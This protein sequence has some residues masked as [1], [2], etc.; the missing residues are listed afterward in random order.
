MCSHIFTD[1]HVYAGFMS[2]C[3]N[4]AQQS[5]EKVYVNGKEAPLRFAPREPGHED[6]LKKIVGEQQVC[7]Y[8][9]CMSSEVLFM[10]IREYL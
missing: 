2:L 5:V 9:A 7:A 8:L 4:S 10:G 6:C 3:E 1:T